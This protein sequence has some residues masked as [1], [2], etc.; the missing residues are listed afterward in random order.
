MLSVHFV[1]PFSKKTYHTIEFL[2]DKKVGGNNDESISDD[3]DDFDIGDDDEDISINDLKSLSSTMFKKSTYKP[4]VE[5]S[6]SNSKKEVTKIS[7]ILIF[8]Y[9]T[10]GTIMDKI[11]TVTGIP[12][13]RQHLFY[14]EDES[15]SL[16]I[17]FYT[18]I[19]QDKIDIDILN[20]NLENPDY[21][22]PIEIDKTIYLN[23]T[24][25]E[26]LS[27]MLNDKITTKD[28]YCVDL[29]LFLNKYIKNFTQLNYNITNLNLVYYGFILKYFPCVSVEIFEKYITELINVSDLLEMN[30]SLDTRESTDILKNKFLQETKL[31]KKIK[32]TTL[33]ETL[34]VFQPSNLYV[35]NMVSETTTI[36]LIELFN[37]IETS[38]EILAV[39]LHHYVNLTSQNVIKKNISVEFN[40]FNVDAYN[41]MINFETPIDTMILLIKMILKNDII[42]G[43]TGD[44][45][46][47]Y[48]LIIYKN[49]T[50]EIIVNNIQDK[51]DIDTLYKNIVENIKEILR[52]INKHS[53]NIFTNGGSFNLENE[54]IEFVNY[55]GKIKWQKS[56]TLSIFDN[57]ANETLKLKDIGIVASRHSSHSGMLI[58]NCA[59]CELDN[60]RYN[61]YKYHIAIDDVQ[62]KND[63][64]YLH[65]Q[66]LNN[67]YTQTF[68]KTIKVHYKSSVIEF[69]FD[70]VSNNDAKYLKMYVMKYFMMKYFDIGAHKLVLENLNDKKSKRLMQIDNKL[71][72][73]RFYDPN[74][75]PYSRTCIGRM[76]P[77]AYTEDEY[78]NLSK[79]MQKEVTAFKNFTTNGLTYYHCNDPKYPWIRFSGKR[80]PKGFCLPCCKSTP[81]NVDSKINR[82]TQKCLDMMCSDD[83]KSKKTSD[84][85]DENMNI[86][87][88]NIVEK[89]LHIYHYGKETIPNG[90]EGHIPNE[91]KKLLFDDK[92]IDNL[93]LYGIDYTMTDITYERI[94]DVNILICLLNIFEKK[95]FKELFDT[96]FDRL[97]TYGIHEKIFKAINNGLLLKIYSTYELFK[98]DFYK[99]INNNVDINNDTVN[100]ISLFTKGNILSK[101]WINN[102][103][104]LI[105]GA[106]GIM[107]II[108][109]NVGDKLIASYNRKIEYLL[110][111]N[112]GIS[113][114][115]KIKENFYYP[116]MVKQSSTI[117]HFVFNTKKYTFVSKI[118]KLIENNFIT[119]DKYKIDYSNIVKILT[120]NNIKITKKYKNIN[121][122]IVGIIT[123]TSTNNDV[124]IPII[125]S[126]NIND[127]IE[128]DDIEN[129]YKQT[130]YNDLMKIIG[131]LN[132]RLSKQNIQ[133]KMIHL[134]LD[135]S[136]QSINSNEL[137]NTNI[138]VIGSVDNN[139]LYY[140]WKTDENLLKISKNI[141]SVIYI[142]YDISDINKSIRKNYILSSSQ[143]YP[144]FIKENA[145]KS[146]YQNNV[147]NIFKLEFSNLLKDERNEQI[148]KIIF[149]EINHT[150]FKSIINIIDLKNKLK[151]ILDKDYPSDYKYFETYLNSFING[152]LTKIN[153]KQFI[154]QIKQSIFTFDQITLNKLRQQDRLKTKSQ[155]YNLMYKNV[156]FKDINLS[157]IPNGFMVCENNNSQEHC[158]KSKPIIPEDKFEE[159]LEILIDDI[160]NTS[161]INTFNENY[162]FVSTKYKKNALIETI[163]VIN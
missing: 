122:Q 18:I 94:Y 87:E 29:Q 44:S 72:D 81:N 118:L 26:I 47:F 7:Q 36:N 145:L 131:I 146:I 73:L 42:V 149:S 82:E 101:I 90:R 134:L 45:Y 135:I 152:N 71:F 5:L 92:L 24:N 121:N 63:F 106:Y 89:S 113:F 10:V 60:I 125:P 21:N 43:N 14:Y 8:E 128:V 120:K 84:E 37:T 76:I 77:M 93:F 97:E 12:F 74:T 50:Y 129:V 96:I 16:P 150:K 48:N 20:I 103:L 56:I 86:N 6:D 99:L 53:F 17:Q 54:N 46:I 15:K 38:S 58:L 32:S 107:V 4:I 115:F 137:N 65:N 114:I 163:E 139:N 154:K 30:Y 127:K 130:D 88:D 66:K 13:Y 148:R 25:V 9:D 141:N 23:K 51:I 98:K 124:F 157:E 123:N 140:Y 19:N 55:S 61:N 116:L 111:D 49:G 59:H 2:D 138:N 3:D 104:E 117:K 83:K 105:Y 75:E 161:K 68:I 110:N 67:F 147:Y 70:N 162:I 158:Y 33:G 109:E 91:L 143:L 133:I 39:R 108:F 95:D 132:N 85:H 80:H 155:V 153:E 100:S 79:D 35:R 11:E 1:N 151:K 160:Y 102:L 27:N 40:Q 57:I 78:K 41:Y 126:I 144:K 34:D 156:A 62:P 64:R 22:F 142:P 31:V 119:L 69:E 112:F 159:L 28:I 52:N 136:R